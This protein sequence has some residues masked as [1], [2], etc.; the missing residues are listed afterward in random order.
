[1]VSG[2]RSSCPTSLMKRRCSAKPAWM[3]S[4]MR[5]KFRASAE[6]SSRPRGTGMRCSRS[7]TVTCSVADR[8]DTSGRSSRPI[9]PC[10]THPATR[11][12]TT[13]SAEK[14]STDRHRSAFWAPMSLAIT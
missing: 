1:M 9:T 6:M 5:L 13:D 2:V 3:R 11:S 12:V 10:A 7:S 4:S 8:S 14:V